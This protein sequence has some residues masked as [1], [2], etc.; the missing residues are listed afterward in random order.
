MSEVPVPYDPDFTGG[1][2]SEVYLELLREGLVNGHA[3]QEIDRLRS[4]N[5]E[6]ELLEPIAKVALR[7]DALWCEFEDPG[8]MDEIYNELYAVC[9]AYRARGDA[10]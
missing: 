8:C 7:L 2:R 10:K 4:R 5:A 1:L 3:H 6:L 9:S